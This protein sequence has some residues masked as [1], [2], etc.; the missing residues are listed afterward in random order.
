MTALIEFDII[1]TVSKLVFNVQYENKNYEKE[2]KQVRL[3]GHIQEQLEEEESS[4]F[5]EAHSSEL[6]E[7]NESQEFRVAEPWELS[8]DG[9]LHESRE[10]RESSQD[11]KK[12]PL[13]TVKA[14]RKRSAIPAIKMM[15][16]KVSLQLERIIVHFCVE[17]LLFLFLILSRTDF[18]SLVVAIHFCYFPKSG[19]RCFVCIPYQMK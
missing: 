8:E 15:P 3:T 6:S 19:F 5:R 14:P 10:E 2:S 7:A 1:P 9:D 4:E 16:L 13:L 17:H 18:H 11:N 12:D